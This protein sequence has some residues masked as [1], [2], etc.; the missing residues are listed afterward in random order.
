M[1]KAAVY[2]TPARTAPIG[3][4][5]NGTYKC[6]QVNIAHSEIRHAS[7]TKRELLPET[8]PNLKPR[9]DEATKLDVYSST[10]SGSSAARGI[11]APRT[12]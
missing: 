11:S 12:P 9:Y 3:G 2:R 8:T 1:G 5:S 7:Y 6:Q 10:T 4:R